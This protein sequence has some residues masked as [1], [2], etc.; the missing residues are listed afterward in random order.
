MSTDEKTRD[1]LGGAA[2]P[3][4]INPAEVVKSGSWLDL[5]FWLLALALLVSA[6][7]INQYLPAYWVPANNV[8][9]RVAAIAGAILVA[10]G[11]LYAT[12]QGK[13]FVRLLKDARVELRRVTWPTKQE[14]MTTTWQV[15]VVVLIMSLVLWAF[16]TLFGWLVRSVIG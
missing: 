9:V 13:A 12:H 6:T 15:L 5:V 16:D 10:L 14:T 1:A 4:Q 11:L 2:I 3:Q 8:W 7:M